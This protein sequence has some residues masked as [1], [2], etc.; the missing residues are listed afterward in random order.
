MTS[1]TLVLPLPDIPSGAYA[2]WTGPKHYAMGREPKGEATRARAEALHHT[3]DHWAPL[4]NFN[5]SPLGTQTWGHPSNSVLSHLLSL[6]WVTPYSCAALC[7][8][9]GVLTITL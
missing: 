2:H 7:T 1:P 8:S 6:F 9:S 3:R 5:V 4:G